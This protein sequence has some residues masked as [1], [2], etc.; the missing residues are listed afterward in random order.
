M[1]DRVLRG[2]ISRGR[3]SRGRVSHGRV[4]QRSNLPGCIFRLGTLI[5][6]NLR[7]GIVVS[8]ALRGCFSDGVGACSRFPG[9]AEGG[10]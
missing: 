6:R 9:S 4:L 5:I 3:I 7:I 1:H 2:R 10:V 8:A